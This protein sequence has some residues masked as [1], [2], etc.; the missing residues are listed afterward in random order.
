MV[1]S[2]NSTK[3]ATGASGN[4]LWLEQELGAYLAG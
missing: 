1:F 3:Y 4:R 2:E